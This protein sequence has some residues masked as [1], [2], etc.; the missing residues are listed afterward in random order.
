MLI[1]FMEKD[2][3]NRRLGN[4]VLGGQNILRDALAPIVAC[5]YLFRLSVGQFSCVMFLAPIVCSAPALLSVARVVSAC[6]KSQVLRVAARRVIA[7]MQ[8]PFAVWSCPI[9]KDVGGLVRTCSSRPSESAIPIL[10]SVCLPRPTLV[11]ATPQDFGPKPP[12][13]RDCPASICTGT[14]TEATEASFDVAHG[15]VKRLKA[16]LAITWYFLSSH[17]N[18]LPNRCALWSGSF[19]CFRTPASRLHYSM[20]GG[21]YGI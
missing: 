18:H 5:A 17:D 15:C 4:A 20:T 7:A 19:G 2:K 21:A 11:L 14:A 6:S 13:R 12:L 3:T 8:H 1:S 16:L 10:V 9:S